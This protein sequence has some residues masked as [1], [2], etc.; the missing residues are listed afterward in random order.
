MM[1][2]WEMTKDGEVTVS[3]S[4]TDLNELA[5]TVMHKQVIGVMLL[6]PDVVWLPGI[7]EDTINK[8]LQEIKHAN[9]DSSSNGN[10]RPDPRATCERKTHPKR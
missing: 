1:N 7:I 8:M 5:I 2:I 3:Y 4:R 10:N 6:E 9:S